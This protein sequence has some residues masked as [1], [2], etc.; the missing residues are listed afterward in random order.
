MWVVNF[1]LLEYVPE[2]DRYEAAH[3]P[4]TAPV[5]EDIPLLGSEPLKVRSNQ[6]DLV[7]N[8]VELASG[9]IRNHRRGLQEKIMALMKHS[10]EEAARRFGMLLNA[11]EA[12]AP[13]HGGFGLGFD[14]LAALICG[15]ESIKEVIAFPKTTSAY[16][17]LTESPNIVDDKQL[18]ELAIK[19]NIK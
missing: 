10:K 18:E 16:C 17:P 3:N 1:P 11:L 9:S 7:L 13:P 6:F 4:F 12:G 8:G 5:E 15:E 14:R 19:L 2:E